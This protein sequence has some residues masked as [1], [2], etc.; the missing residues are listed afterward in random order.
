MSP[1][2]VGIELVKSSAAQPSFARITF[3]AHPPPACDDHL[4][5]ST[6]AS[7]PDVGAYPPPSPVA[8]THI[9][10]KSV[11][12]SPPSRDTGAGTPGGACDPRR[13]LC[14]PGRHVVQPASWTAGRFDRFQPLPEFGQP[15]LRDD[16]MPGDVE[17]P[18]FGPR[19][20]SGVA[21]VP[22]LKRSRHRPLR[23][24]WVD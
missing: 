5:P 1:A 24:P 16:R 22:W 18:H 11:H 17:R 12:V 20:R 13:R 4:R 15:F 21:P 6:P 9:R 19:Y 14:C 23:E 3:S 7:A 8:T 2:P 10:S